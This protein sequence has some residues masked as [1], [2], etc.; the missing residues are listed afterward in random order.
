MKTNKDKKHPLCK[1]C[2]YNC[3]VIE[4]AE[5]VNCKAIQESKETKKQNKDIQNKRKK[6]K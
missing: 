5:I 4:S 6:G 1:G 3:W 2:K